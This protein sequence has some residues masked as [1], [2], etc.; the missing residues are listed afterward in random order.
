MRYLILSES[1]EPPLAFPFRDSDSER[2]SV[3]SYPKNQKRRSLS[4]SNWDSPPLG[5]ARG[6]LSP[7]LFRKTRRLIPLNRLPLESARVLLA[8]ILRLGPVCS[9]ITPTTTSGSGSATRNLRKPDLALQRACVKRCKRN[10]SNS[11]ENH[12]SKKKIINFENPK[13][14]HF[15]FSLVKRDGDE[16]SISSLTHFLSDFEKRNQKDSKFYA[17]V[18][19]VLSN[20]QE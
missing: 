18:F 9:G 13:F 19:L 5:E 1:D 17:Q 20:S 3:H 4:I 10:S 7:D 2:E 6:N 14:A 15:Y 16:Y 8:R 11:G 12:F